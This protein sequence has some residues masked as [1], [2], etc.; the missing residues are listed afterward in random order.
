V[1]G[2]R[3]LDWQAGKTRFAA[4]REQTFDLLADLIE[5]YMDT[6]ALLEVIERGSVPLE[7]MR[8]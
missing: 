7:R 6:G 2:V 3:G 4:I 8:G 1:A 5:E